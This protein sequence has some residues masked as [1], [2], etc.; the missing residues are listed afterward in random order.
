M[1]EPFYECYPDTAV[2]VLLPNELSAF[3]LLIFSP[4]LRLKYQSLIRQ[5]YSPHQYS[6]L[7]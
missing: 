6:L 2:C 4:N 5:E 3:K 7:A 1:T